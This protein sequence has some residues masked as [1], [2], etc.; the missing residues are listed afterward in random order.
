MT[1]DQQQR[2]L[3]ETALSPFFLACGYIDALQGTVVEPVEISPVV[4]RRIEM[5]LHVPVAPEFRCLKL[6]A[7][8][9]HLIERSA[10]IVGG[11]DEDLVRGHEDWHG[12]IHIPVRSPG[13]TPENLSIVPRHAEKRAP[14][15]RQNLSGAEYVDR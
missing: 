14:G 8:L 2:A 7:V 6:V 5:I 10:R 13:N 1:V 4:N 3:R 9:L 15:E 12:G 11:R